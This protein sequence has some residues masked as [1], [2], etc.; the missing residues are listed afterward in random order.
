MCVCECV[1]MYV[2]L[3]AYRC[4]TGATGPDGDACLECEAG[5]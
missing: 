3:C 4:N 2:R 1:C 5:K